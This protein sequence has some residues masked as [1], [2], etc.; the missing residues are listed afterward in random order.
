MRMNKE[1]YAKI[2]QTILQTIFICIIATTVLDILYLLLMIAT[3]NLRETPI[4]FV[5]FHITPQLTANIIFYFVA[6]Y[7]ISSDKLND[8]RKNV[9]TSFILCSVCGIIGIFH[10]AFTVLWA[11]PVLAILFCTVYGDKNLVRLLSIYSAILTGISCLVISIGSPDNFLVYGPDLVIVCLIII[12]A[13]LIGQ[14]MIGFT[15]GMDE[16]QKDLYDRSLDYKE[17][18]DADY[19]TGVSSRSHM[20][21]EG[22]KLLYRASQF[23]PVSVAII[24]IDNFKSVNDTFG[25]ENG[26]VVLQALGNLLTAQLKD[27]VVVGRYGGEEFVIIFEGVSVGMHQIR[28]DR[29]RKLFSE[30][31]FD[32]TD[33]P[34]TFSG[35]IKSVIDPAEFAPTLQQADEALYISKNSGKNKITRAS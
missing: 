31:T 29:V 26:D 17:K 2:R 25:H 33:N 23:N 9:A 15:S 10:S 3:D 20:T 22:Q 24:D 35:G 12:A 32:F 6:K 8:H 28:L 19:L 7:L 11:L 34:I 14:S 21:K 18:L 30:L 27:D 16:I 13:Y 1:L 5:L 4:L